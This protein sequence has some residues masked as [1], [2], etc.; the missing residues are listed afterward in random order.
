VKEFSKMKLS[1]N[2]DLSNKL[3][4]DLAWRKKEL[5]FV[6]G[7]LRGAS[8]EQIKLYFL[9]IA[10]TL[11]YAHW[12]GY[13]KNSTIF[14]L[15]YIKQKRLNLCDLKINL[16]TLAINN[17]ISKYTQSK[18]ISLRSTLV[19]ILTENLEIE[20]SI[21]D[22]KAVSTQS[23][24]KFEVLKEF[25]FV[26]G[27]DFTPFE[28]KQRLID[29][30]LLKIRNDVSHGNYMPIDEDDF[31]YCYSEVV[32]LLENFKEQIINSAI[33]KNYLKVTI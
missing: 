20:A 1:T 29:A 9:R 8:S 5:T 13:I 25:V 26:L 23:N 28:L 12:E 31:L 16:L 32:K 6:M 10:V 17:E 18:K 3:D 30:N 22:K 14:Y 2:E 11:L 15:N 4:E 21:P 27:L 7:N 33:N 19:N 24:L